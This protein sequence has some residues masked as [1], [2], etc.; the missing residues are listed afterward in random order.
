M[1]LIMDFS[2]H[3]SSALPPVVDCEEAYEF[4]ME[5]PVSQKVMAAVGG[6]FREH[7]SVAEADASVLLDIVKEHR[8]KF[9]AVLQNS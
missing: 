9:D 5:S 2:L 4:Y 3:G 6:I 1:I 7:H 8:I